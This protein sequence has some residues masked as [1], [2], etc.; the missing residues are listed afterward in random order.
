[1]CQMFRILQA[2]RV[3]IV[4]LYLPQAQFKGKIEGSQTRVLH[5]LICI[6]LTRHWRGGIDASLCFQ[7][8]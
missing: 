8:N 6:D 3:Q 5:G 2:S 1:M 7:F 4:V